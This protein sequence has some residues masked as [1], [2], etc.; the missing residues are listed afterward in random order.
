[1]IPS[2]IKLLA[3][4]TQGPKF[5]SQCQKINKTSEKEVVM[6]EKVQLGW[7]RSTEVE[8]LLYMHRTLGSILSTTTKKKR[9]TTQSNDMKYTFNYA[10]WKLTSNKMRPVSKK[11]RIMYNSADSHRK[12]EF[13]KIQHCG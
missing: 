1:M 12:Y 7:G 8:F 13:R 10:L 11:T 9:G 2:R 6:S 3:W 4:Q 5:N